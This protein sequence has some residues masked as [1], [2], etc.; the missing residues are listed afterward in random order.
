MAETDSGTV[1]VRQFRP[2]YPPDSAEAQTDRYGFLAAARRAATLEN[3]Q[4]AQVFDVI[5][6]EGGAFVVAEYVAG[7]TLESCLSKQRF[8]TE[9]AHCLLRRIAD[10]L[11]YAHKQGVI[12]G[13]LKPSNVFVLPDERVKVADFA[14]SPRARAARRSFPPEWGHFYLS[15]EHLLAPETIGPWSDQYSLAA[16]AYHLYTGQP[17]FSAAAGDLDSAIRFDDVVAPSTI[18]PGLSQNTDRVLLKALSREPE[19][20]YASIALFM[21]ELEASIA[22]A[23]TPQRSE[24]LS[25]TLL[26]L[27]AGAVLLALLAVV[28]FL[29]LPGMR[30]TSPI[31]IKPPSPKEPTVLIPPPKKVSK[32]HAPVDSAGTGTPAVAPPVP[33]SAPPKP[34]TKVSNVPVE[35]VISGQ[36]EIAV[37][38]R[39]ERPID[40]DSHFGYLDATLGEMGSG[41]LSAMVKVDG[42]APRGKLTLE[43]CLDGLC[44]GQ[45]TV[46]PNQK[47][48]YGDEPTAGHYTIKL[49]M[50][51][52]TIQTFEFQIT[53]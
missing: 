39:G 12:H 44:Q 37:F 32:P 10:A 4:I 46:Y 23:T 51:S 47:M 38:S 8:S 42:P 29:T 43:W 45:K 15:P 26:W 3:P 28:L 48:Q 16:I 50:N 52:K 33:P 9:R 35:R 14:I 7:A 30:L 40:R 17:P 34:P 1:A 41:D 22:I 31:I 20:R 49:R 27:G 2:Q 24:K 36:M 25:P 19:Q 13:D 11:D 18:R 5:D 21:D 6:E 53:P